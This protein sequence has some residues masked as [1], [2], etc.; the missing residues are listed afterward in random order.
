MDV[1]PLKMPAWDKFLK[2][3][4]NPETDVR[5]AVVGKYISLQDSYRSI[6]EAI[7]HGAVAN[8]RA[9]TSSGSIRKT[10][11]RSRKASTSS[12]RR[13]RHPGAGRL[14]RPRHRGKDHGHIPRAQQRDPLFRDLPGAA[15]RRHRVR[16]QRVRPGGRQLQGVRSRH[17]APGHIA[18]RR[19]GDRPREGRHHAARRVPVLAQEGSRV[20]AIY[21]TDSVMERHRHRYEFTNRYRETFE[22][23]GMVF[24]GIHPTINLVETIE[25]PGHPWFIATQFHPEFKSRP[26]KPHPLFRDFITGGHRDTGRRN[27]RAL[28]R[29]SKSI[30]IKID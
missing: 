30:R 13:R 2:S 26:V 5:I 27:S 11:R 16:P 3:L 19:P 28:M 14:R 7:L 21:G 1:K 8:R 6:Y 25:L 23:N 4:H 12:S 29:H 22:K 10:W 17:A 24:G 15:V 9:S 20:R 18:P